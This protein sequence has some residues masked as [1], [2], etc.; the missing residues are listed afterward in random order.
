LLDYEKILIA[1]GGKCAI[2]AAA[3]NGKTKNGES[4]L[5]F[6]VDHNHVTGENRGLL[7]TACN[8]LIGL[9]E[10]NSLRYEAAK[11]YLDKFAA[12]SIGIGV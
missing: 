10:A 6:M 7:C 3:D 8:F 1:Q 2:C 4:S 11:I 5:P 12:Q 9:L